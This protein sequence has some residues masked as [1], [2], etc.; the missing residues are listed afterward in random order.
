M[1]ADWIGTRLLF[2][3]GFGPTVAQNAPNPAVRDHLR[4][5]GH[6]LAGS[7]SDPERHTSRHEGVDC[8]CLLAGSTHAPQ[9]RVRYR[10]APGPDPDGAAY[11][12]YRP[13]ELVVGR[14]IGREKG[15][16]HR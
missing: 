2:T 1:P 13:A 7:S 3:H 4:A 10:A 6:A 14:D 16:G 15:G 12:P 11:V 8:A 9:V 5:G